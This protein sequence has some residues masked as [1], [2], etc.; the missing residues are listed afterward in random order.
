MSDDLVARTKARVKIV[1]V[2]ER[3]GARFPVD[4]WGSAAW[5]DETSFYCPFCDDLGS[6]KAAGRANEL[7]G[8][9]HCFACGSGG[10]IFNAVKQARAVSFDEALQWVLDQFPE[11]VK[12]VDPWA[13][14]G[15]P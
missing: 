6:H 8:L 7:K 14:E 4:D 15:T 13:A 1:D 3:L 11:E 9:W 2:L 5:D 12:E 10:D